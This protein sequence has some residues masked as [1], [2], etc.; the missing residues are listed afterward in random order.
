M[1]KTIQVARTFIAR[2]HTAHGLRVVADIARRM[3]EKGVKASQYFLDNNPIHYD[4]FLPQLNYIA[5]A[6]SPI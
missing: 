4:N 5:P 1:L 6:W 3:Y 2:T